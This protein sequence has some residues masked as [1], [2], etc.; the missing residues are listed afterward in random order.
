MCPEPGCGQIFNGQWSAAE[1]AYAHTCGSK[2]Q[3]ACRLGCDGLWFR[4]PSPRSKH[5][6]EHHGIFWPDALKAVSLSKAYDGR[7]TAYGGVVQPPTEVDKLYRPYVASASSTTAP[8]VSQPSS[9][10]LPVLPIRPVPQ[11]PT[12]PST[13]LAQ[14]AACQACAGIKDA[15][16]LAKHYRVCHGDLLRQDGGQEMLDWDRVG[17]ADFLPRFN[18]CSHSVTSLPTSLGAPGMSGGARETP[19]VS[20]AAQLGSTG[21]RLATSSCVL[22]LAAGDTLGV[23]RA[24]PLMPG[25]PSE[26]GSDVIAIPAGVRFGA[27]WSDGRSRE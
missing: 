5:Y 11:G 14:L 16:L 7:L 22:S 15:L 26:V 1:H 17:E 2:S 27:D 13:S 8:N 20:P 18:D 19:N 6:K 3:F 12:K 4:S 10:P 9:L 24:P 23:S 21:V 25:T